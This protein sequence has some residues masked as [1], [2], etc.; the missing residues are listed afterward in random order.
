MRKYEILYIL[1]ADLE[2]SVIKEL[3]EKVN[4]LVTQNGG[5]IESVKEWGKRRL[6]YEINDMSEGYYVEVNFAGIP[7]VI[8][9]LDRVI[10]ITDGFMRH[11]IV[12]KDD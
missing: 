10:K 12:R 4:G 7:E 6:Q 11:M 5:E 3:M 1:Q 8:N 9:E 2:E